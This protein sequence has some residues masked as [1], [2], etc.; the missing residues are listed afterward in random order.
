MRDTGWFES[1]RSAAASD[2]CVEVRITDTATGMRDSK[3]PERVGQA[4]SRL[5]TTLLRPVRLAK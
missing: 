4:M 3:N 5:L 2:N 1:T